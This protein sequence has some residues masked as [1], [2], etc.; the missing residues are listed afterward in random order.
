MNI[1]AQIA[2]VYGDYLKSDV[3]QMAHHGLSGGE[4]TLYQAADPDI[5]LWPTT[6]T[7]F[8][9]NYDSN[10]NDPYSARE[11][12]DQWCLG[13]VF[14]VKLDSKGNP[15]LD[16]DGNYVITKTVC[17]EANVWIRDESIKE[18]DHYHNSQTTILDMTDL[19]AEP[20]I[21]VMTFEP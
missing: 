16:S 1:N 11:E 17:S 15:V 3:L 19:T 6:E 21:Q 10:V 20:E 14:R 9:G 18:R 5:C 4:I 2:K 12:G 8:S 13:Y 7:R